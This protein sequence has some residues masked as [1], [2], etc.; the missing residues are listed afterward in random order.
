MSALPSNQKPR[1]ASIYGPVKSW[2]FGRSLGIDP[3][4]I[5]STCS[6]NCVYCQ[7][8][9]IQQQT[10]Q[11]QIFVPT[12][13][14][15]SELQV[16]TQREIPLDVVT[17]SGSGEP[18]LA[19]NLGEI[20]AATQEIFKQPKVVLTNSTLL[21]DQLVRKAL[22]LADIVAVK[23]DAVSS[24]QLRQINRPVETIDLSDIIQG[25]TQF[26]QEYQGKMTIQTMVLSA[27]TTETQAK[28]IHLLKLFQPDEI[29]LNIPSRNRT[30]VRQLESRGNDIQEIRAYTCENFQLITHEEINAMAAT[31]HNATKIPVRYPTQN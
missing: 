25:I 28:Y 3:V 12:S 13:Q 19:L 18:T 20:L 14:I 22:S 27:W 23:L 15:I 2:R 21:G 26:R 4:G 10:T 8:G 16:I 17:I 9:N 31:I 7:L 24:N 5:V 30:V 1:C 11:R 6:F 29:Q